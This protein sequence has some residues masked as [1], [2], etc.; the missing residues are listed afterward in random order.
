M[1]QMTVM[2][3]KTVMLKVDGNCKNGGNGKMMVMLK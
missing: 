2:L 1:V 3:E